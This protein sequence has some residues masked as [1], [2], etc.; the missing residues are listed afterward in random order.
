[1]YQIAHPPLTPIR[2][3]IRGR[4]SI[5]RT[6]QREKLITLAT[7]SAVNRRKPYS[8]IAEMAGLSVCDRTLRR[9]M[10]SS[11]YH[12]RVARKKPFLSAK[13]RQVC[14]L[15]ILVESSS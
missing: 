5:L 15:S 3:N 4:H 9:T 11:G 7:A 14:L 6:P 13:T 8:E 1:M 2:N 10:A 12:R